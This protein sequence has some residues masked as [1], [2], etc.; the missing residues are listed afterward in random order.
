MANELPYLS[1]YKNLGALFDR[2]A[3]ARRPDTLTHA[4]LRDTLGLKSTGDRPLISFLK[5]LG[6]LD[7]SS[8]PTPEYALLKNSETRGPAIAAAVRRA[9]A[10]LFHANEAAHTLG[11]NALK[12]LIAQVAGTDEAMTQ[13]IAYTFSAIAKLGDF[14]AQD[15]GGEPSPEGPP[16]DTGAPVTTEAHLPLGPRPLRPEFHYNIQIHLPSNGT[17]ETYLSI[18]NAIRKVFR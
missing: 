15:T 11:A 17:E 4:V 5:T 9:Y 8:R 1:S 16:E 3:S 18:F 6:F 7:G 14:S 12:G 10:P 13:R 2:I